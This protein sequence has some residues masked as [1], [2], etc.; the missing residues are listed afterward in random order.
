MFEPPVLEMTEEGVRVVEDCTKAEIHQQVILLYF[1]Q[2]LEGK[3]VPKMF[4]N[5]QDPSNYRPQTQSQAP[6]AARA[7]KVSKV[8][9]FDF[10]PEEENGK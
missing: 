3:S 8:S 6:Q 1:Y 9:I 2:D 5:C 4:T 7:R 10:V